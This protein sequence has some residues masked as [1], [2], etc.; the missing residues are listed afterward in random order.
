MPC[1]KDR[2]KDFVCKLIQLEEMMSLGALLNKGK[3]KN[4][5][6]K[7]VYKVIDLNTKNNQTKYTSI[8]VRIEKGLASLF[9]ALF[10]I[11]TI[12]APLA[13]VSVQASENFTYYIVASL[14]DTE[15]KPIELK[16]NDLAQYK[17]SPV[18]NDT[19]G[20][21][22][23]LPTSAFADEGLD[24]STVSS[25]FLPAEFIFEADDTEAINKVSEDMKQIDIQAPASNQIV[26]A[27]DETLVD[28]NILVDL[29]SKKLTYWTYT[30]FPDQFEAL[31][32]GSVL[33]PGDN[34]GI[35]LSLNL[36]YEANV[37][38]T[39][40]TKVDGEKV[41]IISNDS[42]SSVSTDSKKQEAEVKDVKKVT[43]SFENLRTL[44]TS[45]ENYLPGLPS[46]NGY[47]AGVTL[48]Q[49]QSIASQLRAKASTSAEQELLTKADQLISKTKQKLKV[50]TVISLP[51]TGESISSI[52][53]VIVLVILVVVLLVIRRL[54]NRKR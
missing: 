8:P 2:L 44:L 14:F 50:T 4:L 39:V 20:T 7:D 33:I 13:K 6:E 28:T 46:R 3:I 25:S 11:L 15:G 36:Y 51:A 21:K 17:I 29:S 24:P 16:R 9:I 37:N 35:G 47:R 34:V 18:S 27:Y 48:K 1:L 53:I 26:F 43:A 38:K 54:I 42:Q 22:A 19:L 49:V 5:N 31:S 45:L 23:Y 41:E 32:D 12:F 52:Y 30:T 10:M 40:E